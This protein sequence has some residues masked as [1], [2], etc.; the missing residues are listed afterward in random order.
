[1]VQ[2][3]IQNCNRINEESKRKVVNK[4]KKGEWRVGVSP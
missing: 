2:W 1:M 4:M 3:G